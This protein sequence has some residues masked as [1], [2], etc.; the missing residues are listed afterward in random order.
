MSVCPLVHRNQ[1]KVLL[2]PASFGPPVAE[3]EKVGIPRLVTGVA[4]LTALSGAS[5]VV[6]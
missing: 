6:L 3:G 1:T 5:V 4:F 2:A